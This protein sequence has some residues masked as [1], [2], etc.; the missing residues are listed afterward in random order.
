MDT[1][2]APAGAPAA[3][4]AEPLDS[5]RHSRPPRLHHLDGLRA[6]AALTVLVN[7]AFQQVYWSHPP[8]RLMATLAPWL[9]LGHNAV[10]LFI[11][12]SG[13][14]LMLPV[15]SYGSLRGGIRGYYSARARRILPAYYAAMAFA[16]ALILTIER[17]ESGTMFDLS[18]G[19]TGPGVLT[20]A[21]L[22]HNLWPPPYLAYTGNTQVCSVFWSV[23]LEWQIYF[24]FPLFLFLWRRLGPIWA[25]PVI[26]VGGAAVWRLLRS[27]RGHCHGHLLPSLNWDG[28]NIL[29]YVFFA[30]GM[31]A[32]TV[33][34]S[35]LSFP[36][37]VRSLVGR[38][39]WV[40]LTATLGIGFVFLVRGRLSLPQPLNGDDYCALLFFC[41]LVAASGEGLL[42]RVLSWRPLVRVG[43]YSYSVYLL[44]LPILGVLTDYLI[45]PLRA[46]GIG[47]QRLFLL[48]LMLSSPLV[49][50]VAYHFSLIF[51]NKRVINMMLER[52]GFKSA[53]A[54]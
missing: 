46:H 20:H 24:L 11:M 7:H 3:G 42:Q 30:A 49:L 29:W 41:L 12:L 15:L 53:P 18:K 44:H 5:K 36:S 38:T 32:A 21:L 17:H 23:A 48:L 16:L 37:R 39:P 47:D 50:F 34:F 22:V 2:R 40:A 27:L 35:P 33:A 10:V 31:L 1:I 6:V 8:G 28:L 43:E 13:F 51:E 25:F 19:L 26:G 45:L 9:Q 54:G 52:V 14:C 4:L